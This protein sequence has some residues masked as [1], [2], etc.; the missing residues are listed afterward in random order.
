M[1]IQIN[2]GDHVSP[3]PGYVAVPFA[4]RPASSWARTRAKLIAKNMPS[5]DTYFKG[6]PGGRSL[7]ALL[8]DRTIWINY[9][10]G[11]PGYGQT[12]MVGG[13]EIAIG[14]LAYTWGRW[15]VLGTLI[16]E[17]AHV[18]GAPGGASL[19]AEEALLHCGLGRLSE[20]NTGT[21]SLGTP[22]DPGIGG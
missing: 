16:H 22:Y 21:D 7:T 8:E 17:L 9:S 10:A 15:T 6:L 20:K 3:Q 11:I 1:S 18:N 13:K 12:N 2:I 4:H 5:A 14:P 19:A